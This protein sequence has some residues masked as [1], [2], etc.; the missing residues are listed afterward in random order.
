M[1]AVETLE[2]SYAPVKQNEAENIGLSRERLPPFRRRHILD[3]FAILA[4]AMLSVVRPINEEAPRARSNPWRD[5]ENKMDSDSNFELLESEPVPTDSA[6]ALVLSNDVRGLFATEGH[7]VYVDEERVRSG[8]GFGE[9]AILTFRQEDEEGDMYQ[10]SSV[11]T[12]PAAPEEG[13]GSRG[14]ILTALY[15]NG[16]TLP[17]FSDST[18]TLRDEDDQYLSTLPENFMP[19]NGY[20]TMEDSDKPAEI[21]LGLYELKMDNSIKLSVKATITVDKKSDDGFGAVRKKSDYDLIA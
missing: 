1:R 15:D 7:T 6:D 21:S 4:F 8:L 13:F 9:F 11:Y 16:A 20:G 5:F 17:S 18:L 12:A 19:I 2:I 10:T 14:S 3:V